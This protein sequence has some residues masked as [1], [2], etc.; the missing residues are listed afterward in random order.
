MSMFFVR[1]AS[2]RDTAA[3]RDLLVASWRDTYA[4]LD[5]QERVEKIIEEWHSPTA[6]SERITRPD[7]EFLV[8]DNGSKL[9]GMA[10]ATLVDDADGTVTLHELYVHPDCLRQGIGRDLFAEI[11]S[12]FPDA[13]LI[14]LEVDPGNAPAIA[15]YLAHGFSEVGRTDNALPEQ[16]GIPALVMEKPLDQP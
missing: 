13:K 2:T 8:A 3:V 5:N 6:V 7:G 14:Q 10:F 9:G 15:F 16:S 12:C 11:E 4:R 1:T